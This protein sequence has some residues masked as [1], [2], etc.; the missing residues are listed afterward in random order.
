MAL[1]QKEVFWDLQGPTQPLD[2]ELHKTPQD[3]T[4]AICSTSST[5]FVPILAINRGTMYTNKSQRVDSDLS[6]GNT[7]GGNATHQ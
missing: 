3:R 4:I 7:Y 5:R 2:L 1:R 6:G